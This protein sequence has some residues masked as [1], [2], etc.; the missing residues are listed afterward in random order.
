MQYEYYDL[1]ISKGEIGNLELSR[2]IGVYNAILNS[3][4]CTLIGI[5]RAGAGAEFIYF[6]TKIQVGQYPVND[7]RRREKIA[8]GF[9][10]SDNQLPWV[11]VLR[12]DF[13]IVPHLNLMP[14][15]FPKCLCIYDRPFEELKITWSPMRFIE[16]IRT[17]LSKTSNGI[18]H[19]SDQPLEPFL[20]ED[21]GNIILP[22]AMQDREE[23]HIYEVPSIGNF[24]SNFIARRNPIKGNTSPFSAII[25]KGAPQES[26]IISYSPKSFEDLDK[27]LVKV[28]IDFFAIIFQR[29]KELKSLNL[30]SIQSRLIVIL[31]LPKHGNNNPEVV[32]NDFYTFLSNDN[33]GS[34]GIKLK[35]WEVFEN[36]YIDL[37]APP[38]KEKFPEIVVSN[39]KPHFS[40]EPKMANILNGIDLE[41]VKKNFVM[42]GV[43]ALG[44]QIFM[45]M[46]RQG[47]GK[48][49]LI[50]DDILLPH[51]LAKHALTYQGIG[52]SKAVVLSSLSNELLN[53]DS[54]SY[55]IASNILSV[56][57]EN[58][59]A[60]INDKF[61][62]AD[63]VI[64]VAASI[65][66]ERS[67][68][69]DSRLSQKRL[70]SAFLN[71]NG[72]QLVV[73][74]EDSKKDHKIDYLEICFYR[75]LI[76]NNALTDHFLAKS[77]IRYSASCRDVTNTISQDNIGVFSAISSK[78]I[79]Q[80]AEDPTQV[81]KV[82][83]FTDGNNSLK[84]FNISTY[85]VFERVSEE[86]RIIY[87]QHF[88]DKIA[89]LRIM[90]LPNET[91][92]IIIGS[93]DMEYK[94]V[95]LVDTI[96]PLDN[97]EY[98][99]MFYRGKAGLNSE[100]ERIRETTSNMLTYV[101]EW[102]SHSKGYS[103]FPNKDDLSLL[104]WLNEN[105]SIEGFP[106]LML[107]IGD[108]SEHS[109]YLSE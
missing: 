1:P 93:F 56:N 80:I 101:G 94:K 102:H 107:I 81:V 3:P 91:G 53:D 50:D 41:S 36:N 78:V 66:V 4:Y 2:A 83:K 95:F 77:G 61:S 74:A 57:S 72:S 20:I 28:S 104:A 105:M 85:Q 86:W 13:P 109:I 10:K 84:T 67:L 100:L 70:I 23:I 37:L 14:D 55:A 96:I 22:K 11:Y 32:S 75:E 38:S 25:I 108:A 15:G 12:K 89:E 52:F 60:H 87:D 63:I 47:Y 19:Q 106:S 29:L 92:G 65:A 49:T 18:L 43:G 26:G 98:P 45:N 76:I 51:N 79:K 58:N 33:L 46:S 97:L 8:I 88:L 6:E 39:L 31:I 54:F 68:A 44:S 35:L 103:T 42:I 27:F 21:S 82:W 59:L 16:D 5:Y 71:P 9:D 40:F 90:K 17:W 7:I 73:L 99:T 69:N 30:K 62:E 34:I 48:W 24:K 64:D